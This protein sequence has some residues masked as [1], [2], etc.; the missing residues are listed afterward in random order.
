MWKKK[1]IHEAH[2][3]GNQI[4][5]GSQQRCWSCVCT[6]Y[7]WD[8]EGQNGGKATPGRPDTLHSLCLLVSPSYVPPATFP[9]HTTPGPYPTAAPSLGSSLGE[10]LS[11]QVVTGMLQ[12]PL[13]SLLSYLSLP[14]LLLCTH[15]FPLLT[16]HSF[17]FSFDL[18][19]GSH[20]TA[21][22]SST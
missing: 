20:Y 9:S 5:S 21:I 18:E 3:A 13:S 15:S 4:L 16:L 19:T 11:T 22:S 7:L 1:T 6:S 2:G 8:N 12:C 10:A 17:F 14:V